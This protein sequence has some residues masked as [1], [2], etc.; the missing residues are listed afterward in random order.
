MAALCASRRIHAVNGTER[1]SYLPTTVISF[2]NTCCVT[3]SAS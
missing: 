3:S 1:C 2:A